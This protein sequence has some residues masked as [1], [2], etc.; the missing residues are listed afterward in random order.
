VSFG[1][2]A[3]I[4]RFG[5]GSFDSAG[6]PRVAM[7]YFLSE[8][9][10]RQG[11]TYFLLTPEIYYLAVLGPDSDADTFIISDTNRLSSP[12]WRLDVPDNVRSIYA[13]TIHLKGKSGGKL[14]FGGTVIKPVNADEIEVTDDN[15]LARLVVAEHYPNAAPT[16]AVTLQRWHKGDTTFIH[17]PAHAKVPD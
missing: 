2:S 12:R 1:D 5:L 6:E 13:G 15:E 7:N 11:W 4:V 16:E 3:A 14:L 17:T 10:R 9:S 8:K